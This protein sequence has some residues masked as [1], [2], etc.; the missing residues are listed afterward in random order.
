MNEKVM[1][2]NTLVSRVVLLVM[3]AL[4]MHNARFMTEQPGTSLLEGHPRWQMLQ[5]IMGNSMNAV[6]MWMQPYGAPTP[7]ATVLYGNL[8]DAR[9]IHRPLDPNT[10]SGIATTT[11]YIDGSGVRRVKG[12]KHLKE[13]QSY[14]SGFGHA[15]ADLYAK[16]V[17][18]H[19][20][21][22]DTIAK[23]EALLPFCS[24]DTWPDA[25]LEQ[26]ARDLGLKF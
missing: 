11:T 25:G 23:L 8:E 21:G 3:L 22:Y 4:L 17:L 15:V 9:A 10:T 26:I 20:P 2:A 7:K 14:P 24:D 18:C 6:R 5:E 16:N 12:N 1:N 19:G 13:S